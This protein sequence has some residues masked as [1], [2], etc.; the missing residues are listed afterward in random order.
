[1]SPLSLR[2]A[3]SLLTVSPFGGQALSWQV[4]G[5]E[6]LW[7]SRDADLSGHHP[8][9]GGVPLCFPWFGKAASGPSHGFARTSLWQVIEQLSTPTEVRLVL[10]LRDSESTLAL[11]PHHFEA[12]I[13]YT[14]T[15]DTL[16]IT[17]RVT[18]TDDQPWA[19]TA[20]L[21]SYL[22]AEVA[23]LHL[24]ALSGLPYHDKLENA[25]RLFD[26]GPDAK[27]PPIPVDAIVPGLAQLALRQRDTSLQIHNRGHD[28]TVVWNP[29][30]A[31][32]IG[33]V[34]F[35]GE[36]EFICLESALALEP[37]RLEPGSSHTLAQSLS[38]SG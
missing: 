15:P 26:D 19:F 12:T 10:A 27:L 5:E 6:Q 36:Q 1:M 20:A 22:Q 24:P 28:A 4:N 29:G 37:L 17:L 30:P 32:G 21:H 35:G 16:A 14:L 23:T 2:C 7:L 8:I 13:S 33:D 25:D 31:H 3:D 11:W 9:R 34:H 18:N 38:I